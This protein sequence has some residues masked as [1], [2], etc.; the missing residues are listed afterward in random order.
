MTWRD[1]AKL[2]EEIEVRLINSLKRNLERHKKWESEEGFNWP[3]WQ[4]EKLKNVRKF[5]AENEKLVSEI[6]EQIDLE[7]ESLLKEQYEEGEKSVID[8]INEA[9]SDVHISPYKKT[10]DEDFFGVDKGKINELIEEVQNVEVKAERAALRLTE[11]VYRQT[12]VRAEMALSTGATTLPQALD[13]AVEDFLK[14][15]I[16]CI[17]Y[18]DGRRVNIVD[19]AAMALKTAALRAYLKGAAKQRDEL[20]IDTVLVSQYGA[21][22][23][24]CLPWQGRVY[25]DDVWGSW[26]GE[27]RG[28]T[29]LSTNGN[30]YPLLSVA[31]ANGLFHPNCRHTLSTWIEG[32]S[33][34]PQQIDPEK[35]R[36]VVELETKQRKL[37]RE[38]RKWKRF[39][40]GT[41]EE[42]IKKKLAIVLKEKQNAL[43][44]FVKEQGDVLRREYWREKTYGVS[45]V[46]KEKEELEKLGLQLN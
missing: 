6:S 45:A 3:A 16:N 26:N 31:I 33:K 37:E 11:D 12:L 14:S 27:R 30:W 5:V 4:A 17:E 34:L 22:S 39:F 8:E 20:G 44:D 24:T 1:L 23:E 35:I 7:T 13:I 15:G 18:K 29:G 36:K 9:A 10:V 25:I 32:V 43:N 21:C 42:K 19:Y 2:F 38:V 46:G 40:E 41:S 28:D